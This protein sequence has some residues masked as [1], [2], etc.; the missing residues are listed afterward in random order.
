M[1][2][3]SELANTLL[4]VGLALLAVG[5]AIASI[6]AQGPLIAYL[7]ARAAE[8][9]NSL[10]RAAVLSL[11]EYFEQRAKDVP[12]PERMKRLLA[13]MEAR[14][15]PVDEDL[16]EALFQRWQRERKA[17]QAAA[18]AEPAAATA[19]TTMEVTQ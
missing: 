17:E 19:A 9:K 10:A 12:G 6:V 2:N 15:M 11:I 13:T 18:A 1:E 5:A 3:L 7:K 4:Q 14:G 8:M 16:A